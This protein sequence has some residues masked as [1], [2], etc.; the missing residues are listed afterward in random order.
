MNL[1]IAIEL[2]KSFEGF[3]SK[4]YLCPAG[5]ATIGYGT[6]TIM[7]SKGLHYGQN[8][9]ITLSMLP[10]TKEEAEVFLLQELTKAAVGVL[11][12][13]PS[14]ANDNKKFNA[15]VDFSYNLGLGR[16]QTSTLRKKIN[17]QKWD[18]AC[19]EL[20]KWNRGGGRVLA[21]LVK[22]RKAEVALMQ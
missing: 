22:R 20:L 13:C 8:M 12:L 1:D 11:W 17:E 9:P 5:V 6:T 21:G 4:P 3:S 7:C 18:E 16:L 19:T 15:I 14:L 10:I 2:C